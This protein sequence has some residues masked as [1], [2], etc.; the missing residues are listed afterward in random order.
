MAP[1]KKSV[2]KVP[3]GTFTKKKLKKK[4]SLTEK[5]NAKSTFSIYI[6]KLMKEK[7]CPD[8]AISAKAMAIMNSFMAD[9]MDR[10]AEEAKNLIRYNNQLTITSRDIQT[11]VRLVLPPELAKDAVSEGVNALY[12]SYGIMK[13]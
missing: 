6:Y 9:I 13:D 1:A 11:A 4:K 2:K 10:I 7:V 12:K 3:S 8:L 5:I